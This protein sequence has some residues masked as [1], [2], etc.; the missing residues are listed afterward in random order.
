MQLI[1]SNISRYSYSVDKATHIITAQLSSLKSDD[2]ENK[3][4]TVY[5][6]ESVD[7]SNRYQQ[8]NWLNNKIL[9]SIESIA[10]DKHYQSR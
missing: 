7:S 3:N 1:A 10:V 9:Y 4:C 6:I 8:I 5:I 2:K